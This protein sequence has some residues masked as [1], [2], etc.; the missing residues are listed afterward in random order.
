MSAYA[1]DLPQSPTASF[2]FAVRWNPCQLAEAVPPRLH[3]LDLLAGI[4]GLAHHPRT[5]REGT[6]RYAPAPL[7]PTAFR[8][9]A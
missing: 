4:D 9:H 7:A 5:L 3:Q 2:P 6:R 1:P 8:I